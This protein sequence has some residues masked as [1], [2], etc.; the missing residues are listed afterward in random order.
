[1]GSRQDIGVSGRRPG[2]LRLEGSDVVVPR[3]PKPTNLSRF[4]FGD[5]LH[6][7]VLFSLQLQPTNETRLKD[8]HRHREVIM[9]RIVPLRSRLFGGIVLNT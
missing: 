8:R 7:S 4:P 1:M 6:L 5:N 3:E 9:S 2:V